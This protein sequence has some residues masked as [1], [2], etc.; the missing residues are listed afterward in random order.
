MAAT[1]E[2][3]REH[4]RTFGRD[5]PEHHT[6]I[7]Q[8]LREKSPSGT[9]I[10]AVVTLFPLG[11][12]LMCLAG[13]ILAGTLIGL[14]VSTPLF[15]LFSP[16]LVPAVLTIGLAVT[17]F[18]TSGAFGI[19]ALSSLSWIINY[20]RG[21]KGQHIGQMVQ[22]QGQ[23]Y[24]EQAKRGVRDTAGYIGQKTKDVG[25]KTQEAAGRT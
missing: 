23:S 8:T 13:L 9:Q 1:T 20:M 16:I 25:Q 4:Y 15:I 24:I 17:G 2:H 22:G 11:G 21:G 6:D 5:Q 12:A 10:L 7:G 3:H 19:T 18:L 14:A